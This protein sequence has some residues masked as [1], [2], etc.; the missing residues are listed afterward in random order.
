MPYLT[1][2]EFIE[3]PPLLELSRMFPGS[4][5][6][7]TYAEYAKHLTMTEEFA[8]KHRNYSVNRSKHNPFGNINI[9]I[10]EKKFAVISKNTVPSIHFVIRHPILRDAI[11]NLNFTV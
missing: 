1:E 11:E 4:G 5:Y 10:H 7:Y 8:K 9:T 6:T 3:A 2:E